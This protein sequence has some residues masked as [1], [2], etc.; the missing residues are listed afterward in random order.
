MTNT[1]EDIVDTYVGNSATVIWPYNFVTEDAAEVV[2]QL[3]DLGTEITTT[4]SSAIY[5]VVL[6]VGGVGGTVEYPLVGAPLTSGFEISITR[7]VPMIQEVT[8]LNLHGMYPQVVEQAFDT[9]VKQTQQLNRDV[10][11]SLALGAANAALLDGFLAGVE[12]IV[13]GSV[14]ALRALT[15]AYSGTAAVVSSYYAAGFTGGGLV[16][17]DASDVVTADN[18]VTVFVDAAGKRWKRELSGS[19][20]LDMAGGI[21]DGVTDNEAAFTACDGLVVPV[22]VPAGIYRLITYKPTGSYFGEGELDY[23]GEAVTIK[24]GR[25]ATIVNTDPTTPPSGDP[26]EEGDVDVNRQLNFALGPGTPKAFVVGSLANTH[27][28]FAAGAANTAGSRN[29]WVG[30]EAGELNE[31]G[32]ANA[33]LGSSAMSRSRF[34]DRNAAV[35]TNA[36]KWGGSDDPVGTL[37]DFFRADWRATTNLDTNNPAVYT[38]IIGPVTGPSM[39]VAAADTD[40]AKNVLVGRDAGIHGVNMTECVAIGY[41]AHRNAWNVD[42]CVAIGRYSLSDGLT[43]NFT[44]AIGEAAMA[45]TQTG[46]KNTAVGYRGLNQNV[47]TEENVTLGY[48]AGYNYTGN[49]NVEATARANA[50]Q[51]VFIGSQAG[52][53]VRQGLNNVAIGRNAMRGD[54][55]SFGSGDENVF[56][57]SAAGV[58]VTTAENNVAIGRSAAAIMTTGVRNVFCGFNAGDEITVGTDNVLLG[59]NAGDGLGNVSATFVVESNANR[60]MQGDIANKKLGIATTPSSHTLNLLTDLAVAGVRVVNARKSGWSTPAGTATRTSFDTATVT[61]EQL[62][63]RVKALIDDLHSSAGHGLIG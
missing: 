23:D 29:T 25:T 57:G 12:A 45:N 10:T 52:E 39:Q 24:L 49:S 55:V 28:G 26:E 41:K 54:T 44:V 6:G 53:Y 14:A 50:G 30:T 1:V 4:L 62:A 42:G 36:G 11:D 34:G 43:A 46:T 37:H 9:V 15:S 60:L 58:L 56:I 17:H 7:N 3:T 47:F 22:F 63:Q 18:G 51:S 31:T 32:Y 19:P 35:G 21:G 8:F 20:S 5:E 59:H 16:I 38:D 33:A 48:R 27:L 2:V 61:L 40:F 13:V